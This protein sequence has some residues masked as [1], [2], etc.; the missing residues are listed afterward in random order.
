MPSVDL[1]WLPLGAG[2]RFVRLNGRIYE[3]FKARSEHRPAMNLYHTA[4]EV[5][6][7]D[8]LFVIEN[9]WPI[10]DGDGTARGVTV[11]G[12]VGTAW[13]GRFGMF[14]YEI[15]SWKDGSIA[16]RAYAVAPDRISRD[17]KV[18]R[19]LI[20]LANVVP[21]YVWGRKPHGYGEMWNSN[22][23]ISWLLTAAG[24]DVEKI[25]ARGGGRAPG[26]RTGIE[27][28]R[29]MSAPAETRTLMVPVGR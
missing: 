20:A 7:P 21:A 24:V 13:L 1:Y 3:F 10:P 23:V 22:S 25:T 17:K 12:P 27:V 5:R 29:G 28:A 4:L 8:G 9:A 14:R 19:N 18:A 2:G 26:W 15:R 11:E 6:L 16:D